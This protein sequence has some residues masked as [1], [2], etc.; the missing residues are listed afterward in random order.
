MKPV[1][2]ATIDM[3]NPPKHLVAVSVGEAIALLASPFEAKG[4]VQ[5]LGPVPHFLNLLSSDLITVDYGRLGKLPRHQYVFRAS[6]MGE[7]KL[8]LEIRE[9]LE[10]WQRLNFFRK[11][12]VIGDTTFL[13]RA[14]T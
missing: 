9:Q 11:P 13:V 6:Q 2:A 10:F 3:T 8:V 4:L 1:I 5:C 7:G 14:T 12:A